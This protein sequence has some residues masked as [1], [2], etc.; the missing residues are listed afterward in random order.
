MTD[1]FSPIVL[2]DGVCGFCSHSVQTIIS[3]DKLGVIK[4]AAL[5][6]EFAKNVKLR[7]P[8]LEKIDSI[9]VIEK[10]PDGLEK[11]YV[12]S[13]AALCIV[14]HL[15]GIWRVLEIAYIVPRFIRDFF[16][17]LFAKNRYKIFG[18]YESCMIPSPKIRARFIDN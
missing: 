4:F 15:G 18:K 2:Y 13:D 5:Q 12:R 7:H 14:K 3:L 16:Y 17:D 8:E 6:G 1:N 9:V 11:V 10:L